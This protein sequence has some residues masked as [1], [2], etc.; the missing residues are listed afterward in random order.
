MVNT[1]AFCLAQE[2][3]QRDRAATSNL[4]NVRKVAELA[5][6]AW[7]REAVVALR[8]EGKLGLEDRLPDA[9]SVSEE[10]EDQ[11]LSENPDRGLAA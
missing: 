5:A 11:L 1:S 8:R 9:A 4:D 3:L 10:V 2:A 6:A 7:A